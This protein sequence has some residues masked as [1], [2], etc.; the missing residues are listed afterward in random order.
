MKIYHYFFFIV[1]KNIDRLF[2]MRLFLVFISIYLLSIN[3]FGQNFI[4][5]QDSSSQKVLSN[6]TSEHLSSFL[7]TYAGD[8][9]YTL[10]GELPNLN[11]HIRP[12]TASL[13]GGLF[14]GTMVWLHFHQQHAWWSGNRGKFHFE[15]DFVSALQVD[16]AGH[17]FGGYI[18]AYYM[19][20]GLM[21]SGLSWD[22]ATFYGS[23][24]GLVYQ[25]YV[26]TEDGFAKSWGFSPS[27]WYFDAIGPIFFLSQHYVPALQ[28][29][30]PKWQYVPSEWTDKPTI[31]RPRTFIDDYNSSTFWW[32]LNVYNILP[33]SMKKYWLPW[34]NIAIGYGADAI[35]VNPDPNGPP[36]QLSQRRFVIGLDYNLVRLL[37][38]GGWFWNWARQSLNFIKLPAPAIE[39]TKSGT[40]FKI[41]YPFRINLGSLKF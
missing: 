34:L 18:T 26:E 37:P 32:S 17:S 38:S 4:I 10:N 25:T 2:Y 20:E 30:T 23:I 31:I 9:R 39:F 7:F 15:E 35:D 19:S 8:K 14:L 21:A 27:D 28:N 1:S 5:N 41:L 3:C 40:Q 11:S 36:D 22:D 33:E 12:L 13:V 29:I 24:F 6:D 16:K